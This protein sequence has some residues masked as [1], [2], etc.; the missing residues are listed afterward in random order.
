[1]TNMDETKFWAKVNK[2]E[3]CWLWT[4]AT[5]M[6][7]GRLRI[8]RHIVQAHRYAYELLVGPIP[9][10]L[11]LD[12]LCRVRS[13]VNAPGHLEPVTLRTNVLRGIG[14]CAQNALVT[15]CPQGHPYNVENTYIPR[16][17]TERQCRACRNEAQRRYVRGRA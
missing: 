11:T 10:G 2:T 4:G 12:H 16:S 9:E 1:V 6:G 7:Y 5:R 15:H 8:G 14:R 3:T 17:R 13:C